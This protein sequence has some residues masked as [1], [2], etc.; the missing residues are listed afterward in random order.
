MA[1]TYTVPNNSGSI[2]HAYKLLKLRKNGTLGPLFINARQVIPLNQWI[3]AEEGHHKKGFAYRPGW[4]AS[5]QPTAPHLTMKNR[6]WCKVL[7]KDFVELHRPESQ[8][9]LWLL[10]SYINVLEILKTK[11]L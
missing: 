8:G 6:V 1:K 7:V 5:T 11:E 3:P 2:R 10:A 9:G 4:H